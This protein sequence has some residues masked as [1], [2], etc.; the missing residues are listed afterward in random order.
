MLPV[1]RLA[2]DKEI[3][4]SEAIAKLSDEFKLSEEERSQLLPSGK[5][6]T[7]AN[8]V[9]W[10]IAYLSKAGLLERVQRGTYIASN[11]GKKVLSN[12]PPSVDVKFLEQYPRFQG[13]NKSTPKVEVATDK[14]TSDHDDGTPEERVDEAG[15]ELEA[16][17][18]TEILERVRSLSPKAFEKLIVDL[19]LAMGYGAGGSGTHVGKSGDGGI[20]GTITEDALGLDVIYIQAKR[21]AEGN[22]VGVEK[23]REF[24]GT[25]DERGATKGVFVT[26]SAFANGARVYSSRSP[27]RL[28]LIDGEELAALMSKY[29]VAVRTYR[30]IEIK[31]IDTDYFDDLEQ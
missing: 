31:K 15:A 13:F 17:L 9:H 3:K 18:K 10:A 4:T 22:S 7:M 27:K 29:G 12:P 23:L 26:T 2:A 14:P 20:D 6:A 21:Y 8:R 1:L 30:K 16:I 11:E 24:A 28:T 25:L 5:Q 19:M